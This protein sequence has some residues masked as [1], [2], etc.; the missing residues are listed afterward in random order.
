MIYRL[1]YIAVDKWD[2]Y[3]KAKSEAEAKEIFDSDRCDYYEQGTSLFRQPLAI[4]KT[5]LKKE[6][7]IFSSPAPSGL[8]LFVGKN[9]SWMAK[10][11]DH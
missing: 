5:Q 9:E 8:P 10:F 2:A 4:K 3:I 11:F 6:P 1:T 7:H